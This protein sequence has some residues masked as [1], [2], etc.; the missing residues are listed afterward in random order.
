M[1]W[2]SAA[3]PWAATRIGL[4][5][6][7][8][9]NAR[10]MKQDPGTVIVLLSHPYIIILLLAVVILVFY[11]TGGTTHQLEEQNPTNTQNIKYPS[12]PNT[13]YSDMGLNLETRG[14][15][16]SGYTCFHF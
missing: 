16:S 10:G 12:Y 5:Q 14:Q 13:V 15:F 3:T 2:S 1:P 6:L 7:G 9:S 8:S 4:T 11:A